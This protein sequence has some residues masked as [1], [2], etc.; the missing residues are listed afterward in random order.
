[1]TRK[2]KTTQSIIYIALL[3]LGTTLS[4]FATPV[5]VAEPAPYDSRVELPKTTKKGPV[6]I[7][8]DYEE[9]ETVV[10]TEK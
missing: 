7:T 10:Y 9:D 3:T 1:M 8:S 2:M 4:A 6:V 5:K